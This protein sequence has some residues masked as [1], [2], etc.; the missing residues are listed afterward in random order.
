MRN[1]VEPRRADAVIGGH[2]CR[3]EIAVHTVD[4]S[5]RSIDAVFHARPAEFAGKRGVAQTFF[6]VD[7]DAVVGSIAVAVLC[8]DGIKIP[9][10]VEIHHT[11]SVRP[12]LNVGAEV[13]NAH[14]RFV[15]HVSREFL[16][17]G[18]GPG[19]V[20][21]EAAAV[22]AVVRTGFRETRINGRAHEVRDVHSC[23]KG[24]AFGEAVKTVGGVGRE[25]GSAE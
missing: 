5:C 4:V 20:K 10:A 3:K 6:A 24:A 8:F 9:F 13:R 2:V 21:P 7:H 14:G 18:F 15:A 23:G 22:R 17:A 1:D 25:G 16:S 19:H 12:G 11:E